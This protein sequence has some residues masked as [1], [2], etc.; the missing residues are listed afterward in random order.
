MGALW[1]HPNIVTVF[2]SAFTSD[3]RPCI[4]MRLFEEGNYYQLLRRNGSVPVDQLLI[5]GVKIAGALAAAHDAGVIHGDVKPHNIFKSKFGEPAL[6]D[7]GIATFVGQHETNELKG[8]SVHYAAPELVEG[9]PGP[10]ADQYSLAATLFTLAVGKRPF[11]LPDGPGSDSNTQVLLRV[12]EAPTPE[13]PEAFPEQ[14]RDVIRRAMDRDPDLR[15]DSLGEFGTALS[16][17]EQGLK[18]PRTHF[19]AH[20]LPTDERSKDSLKHD[21]Q[22]RANKQG[23][24]PDGADEST[25]GGQPGRK[26]ASS[27]TWRRQWHRRGETASQR[28]QH[29]ASA[30]E[31]PHEDRAD[32]IVEPTPSTPE[33]STD[34]SPQAAKPS[35]APP[36][37]RTVKARVCVPCGHAHPVSVAAC[38]RCG[39]VLNKRT[40]QIRSL[41]QPELGTV[42]LS[43]GQVESLDQDLVIGRHPTA[44][45]LEPHQ[46]AVTIGE[47]DRTISRRHIELRLNG[48]DL[49]AKGLGRNTRLEHRG[50][51]SRVDP[52]AVVDLML[53]DTSILEPIPGF[54]T[55]PD[56]TRPTRRVQ[57][58]PMM[59]SRPVRSR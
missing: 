27:K 4:V 53:G 23:V 49:T 39:T 29:P 42:R 9:E 1:D 15:Y 21:G 7:F 2:A 41:S 20:S 55:H 6:G 16:E 12:L 51:I 13:L 52:G 14:L 56:T 28:D 54:G 47:G 10:K 40:S 46:R 18:L 17:V 11:E 3:G 19:P 35:D 45:P 36:A 48:W 31:S 8:L 34:G 37:G 33:R 57:L 50:T 24:L 32:A 25:T 26:R 38:H 59:I 22:D 30:E 43:G 5:V 44:E 58:S